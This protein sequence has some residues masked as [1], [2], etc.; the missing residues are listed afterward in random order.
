VTTRFFPNEKN[1]LNQKEQDIPAL[2][3]LIN[4]RKITAL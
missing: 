3:G 1:I 4:S 2:F